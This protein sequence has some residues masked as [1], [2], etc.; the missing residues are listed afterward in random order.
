MNQRADSFARSG[1]REFPS[2]LVGQDCSWV[3]VVKVGGGLL[4]RMPGVQ[5]SGDLRWSALLRVQGRTAT[6][7]QYVCYWK[8]HALRV[9]APIGVVLG[10]GDQLSG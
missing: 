5:V 7:P 6:A 1:D 2:L 3:H 10:A 9:L 4:H 8:P